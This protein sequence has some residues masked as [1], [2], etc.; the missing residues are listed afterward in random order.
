MNK[1]EHIILYNKCKGSRR[2][3]LYTR[4][5]FINSRKVFDKELR[6]AERE[7]NKQVLNEYSGIIL[8][9]WDLGKSVKYQ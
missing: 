3:K 9:N 1:K 6:H 4:N 2:E 5:S 8:K 7:Y